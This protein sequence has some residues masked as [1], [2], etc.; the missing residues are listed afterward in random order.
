MYFVQ[1]VLAKDGYH[2]FVIFNFHKITW[3]TGTA[4]NGS[5]CGLGGTPAK[6]GFD[7]GD[8]TTFYTVPGSCSQ[9]IIN[10]TQTS[11][12]GV[13]GKWIFR[14]DDQVVSAVVPTPGPASQ[15]QLAVRC[16]N[17]TS[18]RIRV[19]PNMVPMLGRK[20]VTLSGNCN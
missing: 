18:D 8:S 4:S 5:E 19:H 12:V 17:V 9:S 15:S 3:T 2:S 13:P 6:S 20:R 11:N 1:V 10:I 7:L 14:I 16:V